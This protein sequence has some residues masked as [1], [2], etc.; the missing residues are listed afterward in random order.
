MP[1]RFRCQHCG[2]LLGIARRKSGT[3][4]QCPTCQRSVLVPSESAATPAPV[5]APPAPPTPSP[6]AN[7]PAAPVFERDD[8]EDFLNSPGAASLPG[9]PPVPPPPPPVWPPPPVLPAGEAA[10]A[11]PVESLPVEG[12][13]ISPGKATV[14]T[15]VLILLLALAFG[16]GLVV[17]RFY[18]AAA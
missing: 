17:G 7:V 6:A 13:V 3:Q 16:A 9:R 8:F 5:A 1:I 18:L 15:V 12:V 11:P 14:L 10:P 2:Q 4:V